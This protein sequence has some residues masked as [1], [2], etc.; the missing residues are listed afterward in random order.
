MA[1]PLCLLAALLGALAAPPARA[2]VTASPPVVTV[3]LGRDPQVTV[4]WVFERE[5]YDKLESPHG[6]FIGH[7]ALAPLAYVRTSLP[8]KL[9]RGAGS[10]TEKIAIPPMLLEAMRARGLTQVTYVR[11]FGEAEGSVTLEL[12]GT[13]A[14]VSVEGVELAFPGGAAEITVARRATVPHA[15]ATVR[16]QGAGPLEAAWEVDGKVHAK[17]SRSVDALGLARFEVPELPPLPTEAPGVHQLRFVPARLAR[18][19][20]LPALAYRVGEDAPEAAPAPLAL[21]APASEAAL[22]FEE[23]RL[24]WA[25]G[26]SSVFLVDLRDCDSG[27]ALFSAHTRE[28]SYRLPA[29]GVSPYLVPGRVICWKVIGFGDDGQAIEASEVRRLRVTPP[30]GAP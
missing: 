28:T 12:A 1:R 24:A 7:F 13:S 14:K 11:L 10:V 29:F 26:R 2:L 23:V 25:R 8:A 6:A 19:T 9:T 5:P 20:A 3:A 30:R 15:V 18:G 21:T 17:V 16:Y 27:A 22:P 4:K